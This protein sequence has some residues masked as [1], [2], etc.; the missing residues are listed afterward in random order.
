MSLAGFFLVILVVLGVFVVVVGVPGVV[1]G[2][3]RGMCLLTGM[4]R[5][6]LLRVSVLCVGVLIIVL[7]SGWIGG[8]P[9]VRV[10]GVGVSAGGA[11][12]GATGVC[13]LSIVIER[14][15]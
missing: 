12:E 1:M 13:S 11:R 14:L 4:V 6:F 2:G 10:T 15:I 9:G 8:L 3:F 7:A 5:W